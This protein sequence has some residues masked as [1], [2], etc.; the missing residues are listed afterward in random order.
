MAGKKADV[1][2]WEVTSPD[3][4][5]TTAPLSPTP[6]STTPPWR[7]AIPAMV[8]RKRITLYC[9][10]LVS[11]CSS[12]SCPALTRCLNSTI[13]PS[14][15]PWISRQ[16]WTTGAV[17]FPTRSFPRTFRNRGEAQSFNLTKRLSAVRTKSPLT[18]SL[19]PKYSLYRRRSARKRL[20]L[21]CTNTMIS[22]SVF[23]TTWVGLP[24]PSSRTVPTSSIMNTS[25]M[26]ISGSL[27]GAFVL[28]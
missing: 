8:P 5:P 12:S 13:G 9:C 11:A 7:E 26:T 22:V 23:S 10:R 28:P 16:A 19:S 1:Y 3:G 15:R 2:S 21:C 25:S 27:S 6:I 14:V 17:L 4:W 18:E 24:S 20:Q